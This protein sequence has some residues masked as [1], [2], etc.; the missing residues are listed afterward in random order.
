MTQ[1]LNTIRLIPVGDTIEIE[2]PEKPLMA[3][4]HPPDFKGASAPLPQV[5]VAPPYLTAEDWK[6]LLGLEPPSVSRISLGVPQATELTTS[7]SGDSA[8]LSSFLGRT[9]NARYFLVHL[10]CSFAPIE[11]QRFMRAAL[12]VLLTVENGDEGPPPVAWSMEPH[13]LAHVTQLT[14]TQ[15]VDASFKFVSFSVGQE[16]QSTST[17][18]V[19]RAFN[20]LQP[21]PR[22]E[23]RPARRAAIEGTQR[24]IMVVRAPASA[25]GSGLPV[26][27]GSRVFGSVALA[28]KLRRRLP[29]FRRHHVLSLERT[30]RLPTPW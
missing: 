10:A 1:M 25:F 6:E 26:N 9:T 7:P 12:K 20:E 30:F 16:R 18:C 19:V 23:F 15:K 24:L 4:R 14:R 29:P 2:L 3:P 17:D 5:D 22:W 13:C 27:L 28:A 21:D 8:G 11:G